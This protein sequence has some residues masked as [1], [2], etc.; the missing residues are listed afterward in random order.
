MGWDFG[1]LIGGKWFWLVDDEVYFDNFYNYKCYFM[2][3]SNI[4]FL[5]CINL[6]IYN[7]ECLLCFCFDDVVFMVNKFVL[8]IKYCFFF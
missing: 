5:F 1:F 2:E 6:K 3:V 4:L 8:Y 7:C